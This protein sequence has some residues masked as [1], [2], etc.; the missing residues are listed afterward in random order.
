MQFD[1]FTL[2]SQEAI[3]TAQQ[4]AGQHG[5]QEIAP[6]HLAKAILEQPDGV[7]VPV[8]QKLGIEPSKVLATVNTK[9]QQIPQV[10]GS[11][12]GQVYISS[13]CRKILDA[14]FS[15]ASQM[16]D[17]YVSQE[18]LFLGILKNDTL[19]PVAQMLQRMGINPVT[20]L[21]A[22][23]AIRGN[24]RVTDPYPE[25]KYQALEKYARNLTDVARSGKLFI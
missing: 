21:Q 18:H 2:K 25:D 3:Q 1:K 12:A 11:G 4:I 13:E 23:T 24:Q 7:V 16:Q 15:T 14:A 17:E 22:L 10:S 19:A 6:A 9:I 5:N 8:I 20:F